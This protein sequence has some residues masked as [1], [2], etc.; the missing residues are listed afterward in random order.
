MAWLSGTGDDGQ[1][2]LLTA[3]IGLCRHLFAQPNQKRQTPRPFS[4]RIGAV[5]MV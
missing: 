2:G 3:V 4:K 5:L 1:I